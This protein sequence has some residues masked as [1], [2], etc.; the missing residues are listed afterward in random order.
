MSQA[1][2]S[3]ADCKPGSVM[4]APITRIN[5]D[6]RSRAENRAGLGRLDRR[7][8]HGHPEAPICADKGLLGVR[9]IDD[10]RRPQCAPI[11][12][13]PGSNRTYAYELGPSAIPDRLPGVR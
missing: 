13:W 12:L 2:S 11:E 5:K 6:C 3:I 10:D 8:K 7:I 1:G 9:R 4:S